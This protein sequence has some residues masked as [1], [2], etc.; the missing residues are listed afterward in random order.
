ML[1]GDDVLIGDH[2][3]A[4]LYIER[5]T[6]LGVVFSPT[7][8]YI[9]AHFGEFAKRLLYRGEEISPFPISSI[10]ESG[11]KYYLLT[12][13]LIELEVK[14]W[15]TRSGIPEAISIFYAT[16]K[17]RNA[18]FCAQ[19]FDRSLACELILKCIRGLIPATELISELCRQYDIQVSPN[20]VSPSVAAA[21]IETS[22][23]TT[24]ID[25]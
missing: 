22:I 20:G 13:L 11:K 2:Q 3:L 10:K 19:I 4:K 7:K 9:S 8:T 24:F 14:G 25:S 23:V 5:I 16:V 17:G 12:N 15:K 18:T 6:L 1:L 21:L